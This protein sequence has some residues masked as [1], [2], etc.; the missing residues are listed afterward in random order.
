MELTEAEGVLR[1]HCLA[2]GEQVLAREKDCLQ[3]HFLNTSLAA[4]LGE[5][6]ARDQERQNQH[7]RMERRVA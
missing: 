5:I 4:E 6:R 7:T 1:G 3:A 2:L